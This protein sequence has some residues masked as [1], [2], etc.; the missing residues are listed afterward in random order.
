MEALTRCGHE[1]C[2][3]HRCRFES[4][5]IVEKTSAWTDEEREKPQ[6]P[7]VPQLPAWIVSFQP[8]SVFNVN[9]WDCAVRH[10][11]QE[12]GHWLLLVEPIRNTQRVMSRSEYRRLKAQVG[13]KEVE[14]IIK[15][16]GQKIPVTQAE[17][18]E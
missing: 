8:G 5:A 15:A 7:Q 13:K 10:V 4:D 12:E 11:G 6:P 1:D 2:G 18:D 9:G 3:S 16:R 14:Q 17:H